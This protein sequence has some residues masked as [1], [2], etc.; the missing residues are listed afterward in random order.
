MGCNAARGSDVVWLVGLNENQHK[1]EDL[2]DE[3]DPAHWWAQTRRH[4]DQVPPDLRLSLAVPFGDRIIVALLFATDRAPHVHNTGKSGGVEREVPWRAKETTRTAKRHELELILAPVALVHD[5][6]IL[7][8]GAIGKYAK[9]G[10]DPGR[11]FTIEVEA[12]VLFNPPTQD[13]TSLPLTKDIG[14]T[15]ELYADPTGQPFYSVKLNGRSVGRQDYPGDVA[16]VDKGLQNSG[17]G[18]GSISLITPQGGRD[19]GPERNPQNVLPQT[20]AV[21]VTLTMRIV[22]TNRTKAL[23]AGLDV[24][25]DQ[26]QPHRTDWNL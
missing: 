23:K 20:H 18:S 24:V 7:N 3:V 12:D 5:V 8:M 13:R 6:E 25:A 14:D 1:I 21:G 9:R 16:R 10:S 26:Q 22:G 15:V 4:F 2:G 17:P 11:V 19:W